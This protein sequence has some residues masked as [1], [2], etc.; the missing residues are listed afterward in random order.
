MHCTRARPATVAAPYCQLLAVVAVAHTKL[1]KRL[2][3]QVAVVG[4]THILARGGQVP[5]AIGIQQIYL[6]HAAGPNYYALLRCGSGS[7]SSSSR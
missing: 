1:G 4:I 2:G 6:E 5:A 3:A 7:S